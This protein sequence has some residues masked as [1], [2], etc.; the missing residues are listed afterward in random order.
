MILNHY[1]LAAFGR[2]PGEMSRLFDEVFDGCRAFA[3]RRDVALPPLNVWQD[4]DCIYVQAEVPGL[5]EEDLD[6]HVAG[7]E[8]TIQ[9]QHRVAEDEKVEYQHRERY[10]GKIAR[11]LALPFEVEAAKVEANLKDGL[12]TVKLPMAETAKAHKITVS[13]N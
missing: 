8:L 5:K 6:I 12:L 10:V 13:S 9:G 3:P 2:L 7:N 4:G 1:P 11:T